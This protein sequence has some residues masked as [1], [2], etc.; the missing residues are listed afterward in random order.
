MI[1]EKL[2]PDAETIELLQSTFSPSSGSISE[3]RRTSASKPSPQN[4]ASHLPISSRLSAIQKHTAGDR[5]MS[6]LDK[7]LYV[8]DL[9]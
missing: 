2:L 6:T 8:A 4:L 1:V 3:N 5:Q 7:I 9:Y